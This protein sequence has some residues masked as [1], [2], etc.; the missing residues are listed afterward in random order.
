M[1]TLRM[2]FTKLSTSEP[3][4][5]FQGTGSPKVIKGIFPL[6]KL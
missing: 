2:I 3:L 4:F 1:K 6:N 5:H